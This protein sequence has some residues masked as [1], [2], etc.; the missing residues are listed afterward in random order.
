MRARSLIGLVVLFAAI[1]AGGQTSVP[2]APEVGTAGDA[3]L[4]TLHVYTNLI[5]IPTLVL[6]PLR[7]SMGRVAEDRFLMS[8]DSGPLFKPTHVREE[9]NDPISLV[10]LLD[11]S[12][13]ASGLMDEVRQRLA[14]LAPGQLQARDSISMYV[15][16][17]GLMRTGLNVPVD[18]ASL[19]MAADHAMT[20]VKRVQ[21]RHGCRQGVGLWDA[22]AMTVKQA[23]KL[24][25]RRV[26]LVVSDG[27]DRGSRTK[28]PEVREYAQSQGIAVFGLSTTGSIPNSL[29]GRGSGRSAL[30]GYTSTETNEDAFNELCELTGGMRLY[31]QEIEVGSELKRLVKLLRE[32]YIVEFPRSTG[33][34]AGK[35]DLVVTI[36][37]MNAFVRPAGISVPLPDPKILADPMT[38]PNDLTKE[39]VGG[40]RRILVPK[41]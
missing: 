15:M 26:M 35:H 9:G 30:P 37:R 25:G 40:E 22:M 23:S 3:A 29:S 7:G 2:G 11:P 12:G 13:E 33:I 16:S 41:Q 18:R 5:Q 36:S 39:P 1:G 31:A 19:Q 21:G 32:R 10:V 4:P 38:L 28:W 8:V 14:R 34:G 17:C 27:Q 24:P 20:E 6:S